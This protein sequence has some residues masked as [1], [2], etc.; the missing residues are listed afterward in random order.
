MA[1][2]MPKILSCSVKECSYNKNN[3]CHTPAITIGGPGPHAACDTFVKMSKKGGINDIGGVGACKVDDCKF[4]QSLEC[5]ATG[6][7]VG[8]HSDHADCT[9]FSLR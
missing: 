4:N 7:N 8:Y 1:T 3:E 9:T 2:K 5:G 6:I